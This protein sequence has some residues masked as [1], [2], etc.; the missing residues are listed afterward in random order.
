M[1]EGRG[2][3]AVQMNPSVAWS[4][5]GRMQRDAVPGRELRPK[6][7]PEA[8]PGAR[9]RVKMFS[10][11]RRGCDCTGADQDS[12][13]VSGC[14]VTPCRSGNRVCFCIARAS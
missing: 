12:R 3:A 5:D 14:A 13:A 8:E 4:H 7:A 2:G 11:V 6:R 1:L 10:P 9:G